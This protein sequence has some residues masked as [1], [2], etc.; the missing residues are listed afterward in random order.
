MI[1]QAARSFRRT[2]ERR[3]KDRTKNPNGQGFRGILFGDK[4]FFE[5]PLH[6]LCSPLQNIAENDTAF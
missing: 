2:Y 6:G 4:A 5:G 3:C 1:S